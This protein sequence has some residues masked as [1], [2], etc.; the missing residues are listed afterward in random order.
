MTTPDYSITIHESGPLYDGRAA[1]A[2]RRYTEELQ[3]KLA[4]E[5]YDMIQERLPQVIRH[6]TG[7]YAKSIHTVRNSMNELTVTDYP[8]VYG[9][10][11]EGVGSRNFPKTRFRGYFTF[12]IV[13]QALEAKSTE[14]A[15]R[16]LQEKY[17]KEMGA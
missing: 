9:P 16:L 4:Q 13:G 3:Q 5:A 15:D 8:I 10:W 14:I 12:R 7:R 11:L 1:V 2:V 6:Y 17:L